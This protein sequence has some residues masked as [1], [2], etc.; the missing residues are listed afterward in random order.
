MGTAYFS[1]VMPQDKLIKELADTG[2]I[3]VIGD[4]ISIQ[5]TNFKILYQNQRHRDI[6]GDQAGRYCFEAYQEK[7]QVCKG[8]HLALSFKDGK[9][10]TVER[11]RATAS[12]IMYAE[13]TS[14]VLRDS[15][16]KIIA[17]IEV[18][19]DIT[20]RKLM[21]EKVARDKDELE[22]HIAE[23]TA[24]LVGSNEA[25]L[26]EISKRKKIEENLRFT[27]KELI[28]HLNE[29]KES[30]IA[31]KVLLKQRE[32][33][34]GEVEDNILSNVKHLV[35]PYIHKL[36]KNRAMSEELSYLNI[37]ESNLNEII[38]PFSRRLASNYIGLSQKEIRIADL[39]KDGKQDKDIMELL[40]IS[41]ET[42][43]THRKNIRKKLGIYSKRINLR[44]YLISN[45]K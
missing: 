30:N 25:L 18:I 16:G 43:K 17:G 11:S 41:L 13:N 32:A 10:H 15:T 36:K 37:I 27:E 8:C 21:E 45:V 29:L 28:I 2:I 23:R 9:N 6:A 35:S 3:D 7:D 34:K 33:D 38:S 5:D 12:G 20:Q 24:E 42:V 31:L 40:N 22:L 1:T 26:A 44:T 14:S 4:P 39:I 19:R